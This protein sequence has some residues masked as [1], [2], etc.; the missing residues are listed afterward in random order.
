MKIKEKTCHECSHCRVCYFYLTITNNREFTVFFE[1]YKISL[2]ANICDN[3]E[4]EKAEN[5]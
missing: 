5:L 1:N 2:F 3:Y 4:K